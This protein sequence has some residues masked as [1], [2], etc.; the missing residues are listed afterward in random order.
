MSGWARDIFEINVL[1]LLIT[2]ADSVA[3][4]S[5]NGLE[6]AVCEGIEKT[7][8]GVGHCKACL[9]GKYP[10]DLAW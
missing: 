8:G 10:V 2:G 4:L 9:T 7:E 5:V 1:N 3:Y 6:K